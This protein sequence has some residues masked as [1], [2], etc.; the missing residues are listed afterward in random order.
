LKIVVSFC[1]FALVAACFPRLGF[2]QAQLELKRA[3]AQIQ[4]L[5]ED[6]KA[7]SAHIT[8]LEK[9]LTPEAMVRA[10]PAESELWGK[11]NAD[12]RSQWGRSFRIT[13]QAIRSAGCSTSGFKII[14]D[15]I[16]KPRQGP[17][18][19]ASP[20]VREIVIKLSEP[21]N[22][23]QCDTL[24][25]Y[26]TFSIELGNAHGWCARVALSRS[27][28]ELK[29]NAPGDFSPFCQNGSWRK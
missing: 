26:M 3:Q 17:T 1:S 13:G 4:Q 21:P 10:W 23:K 12:F 27:E 22:P 18:T 29:Q 19:A 14:S 20:A 24:A 2:A 6:L 25:A 15:R 9:E 16:V 8:L 28:Q 11:W 7:Q 5:K